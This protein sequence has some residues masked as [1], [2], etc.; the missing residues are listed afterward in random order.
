MSYPARAEGLVNMIFFVI[1]FLQ[2]ITLLCTA[3]IKNNSPPGRIPMCP[4]Y[5]SKPSDGE[6]PVLEIWENLE[7][8]ESLLSCYYKVHSGS[9]LVGWLGF[10]AYQPL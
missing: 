9:W 6:A 5:E 1:S 8:G 2:R 3:L 10:M 7:C 4:G